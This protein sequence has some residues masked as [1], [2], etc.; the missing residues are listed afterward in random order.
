MGP[1]EKKGVHHFR[2]TKA[3]KSGRDAVPTSQTAIRSRA[4]VAAVLQAKRKPSRSR[5]A[6]LALGEKG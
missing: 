2:F 4:F 5:E 6:Q 1:V 3:A